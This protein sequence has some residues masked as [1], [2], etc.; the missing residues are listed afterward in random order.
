M[1]GARIDDVNT[2]ISILTQ[3]RKYVLRLEERDIQELDDDTDTPFKKR[4][5]QYVGDRLLDMARDNDAKEPIFE[6][7]R[8]VANTYA[9]AHPPPVPPAG[10]RAPQND[11]CKQLRRIL[12][13]VFDA[14]SA[15]N[16]DL[17]R[18]MGALAV[19]MQQQQPRVDAWRTKLLRRL[20][21]AIPRDDDV[22]CVL[23]GCEPIAPK[24]GMQDWG[25]KRLAELIA[26]ALPGSQ[27]L[28]QKLHN[29]PSISAPPL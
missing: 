14:A 1:P 7:I 9:A 27:Q 23:K 4:L 18:A 25:R 19:R 8:I 3:L 28:F 17:D 5:T 20:F 24:R 11:R 15:P 22:Q 10:V 29:T 2:Y 6:A 12:R 16:S 21:L 26:E 13:W